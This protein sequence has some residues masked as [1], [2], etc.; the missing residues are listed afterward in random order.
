MR[1]ALKTE[2]TSCFAFAIPVASRQEDVRAASLLVSNCSHAGYAG[3]ILSTEEDRRFEVRD[4]ATRA[5]LACLLAALSRLQ[6]AR[7]AKILPIPLGHGVTFVAFSSL[8]GAREVQSFIANHWKASDAWSES[9]VEGDAS[10]A[11][12]MFR[13]GDTPYVFDQFLN[14][15][16]I[17][18]GQRLLQQVIQE[19]PPLLNKSA[20]NRHFARTAIPQL[21]SVFAYCSCTAPLVACLNS[22]VGTQQQ[23]LMHG[24][25]T[26]KRDNAACIIDM[27]AAL[28]FGLISHT[29]IAPHSAFFNAVTLLYSARRP[30][31]FLFKE[32]RRSYYKCYSL[33]QSCKSLLPLIP[34]TNTDDAYATAIHLQILQSRAPH[35]GERLCIRT[36][37]QHLMA[38]KDAS[39]AQL[40]RDLRR[41]S[42][43]TRPLR[44]QE[45]SILLS[46]IRTSQSGRSSDFVYHLLLIL[47]FVGCLPASLLA[48]AI[49]NP[50]DTNTLTCRQKA[51]LLTLSG[52]DTA[53]I[54]AL[55]RDLVNDNYAFLLPTPSRFRCLKDYMQA[56]TDMWSKQSAVRLVTESCSARR[57]PLITVILTTKDPDLAILRLAVSS[58]AIQTYKQL[59]LI[60]VNDG[61]QGT[62]D[63]DI[64]AIISRFPALCSH[65][66][67]LRNNSPAGQYS[68][69]NKALELASGEFIAIQDDDDVSHPERLQRQIEYMLRNPHAVATCTFHIRISDDGRIQLDGDSND[70]IFGDC[71]VSHVWR[72]HVFDDVG[73]FA[74]VRSRGDVEF[75]ERLSR[76]YGRTATHVLRHPLMLVR[77]S[78]QTVSSTAEYSQHRALQAFRGAM[79]QMPLY[80]DTETDAIGW[81]PCHLRADPDAQIT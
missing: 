20:H 46:A 31:P 64:Q 17:N 47:C 9:I 40:A 1:V 61:S 27:C 8:I 19:L 53:F 42:L 3:M 16:G 63:S 62:L 65:T 76:R 57:D 43:R 48:M 29:N 70:M 21:A 23:D 77:G 41:A 66:R 69:R 54:T 80:L 38:L 24:D 58:I 44:E 73:C 28:L 36:L 26:T 14:A 18:Q 74:P 39:I 79:K 60:V 35:N 6:C 67:Y 5:T 59:E 32:M 12:V 15:V 2:S 33:A 4:G 7:R 25:T 51:T 11:A 72:R 10:P 68:S 37:T 22:I 34:L 49:L 78:P 55:N 71:P 52:I 30:A 81:I 56:A 75:R 13:I 50:D 45:T